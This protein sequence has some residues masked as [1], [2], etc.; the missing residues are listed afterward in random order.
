VRRAIAWVVYLESHAQRAYGSVT[1]ASADTAK[2]ILG[3][4]RSGHLKAP[5]GSRDVWRPRLTDRQAVEA[6][7]KMLV[8]Y[9]WLA[10]RR[11]ETQGRPAV[12]YYLNPKA[13]I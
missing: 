7:L 10:T 5:F 4:L 3:K 6:G 9:D 12:I 13:K 8:E 1:A 11:V 2:A